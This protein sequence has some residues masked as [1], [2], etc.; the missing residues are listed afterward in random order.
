MQMLTGGWVSKTI[1]EVSRLNIPDLLA[2]H[3]P[4]SAEILTSQHQVKADTKFLHRALR[5]LASVGVFTENENGEFGATP[6]SEVL[7]QSS[8]VSVKALAKLFGGS[9]YRVWGGLGDALKEGK[10]QSKKILGM[11][12]WDYLNANP[13]ELEEFAEAMKA[14]SHNSL[15]GVLDHCDFSKVNRVIDVAGGL[16]HLAIALL[17]KYEKLKA[18]ILDMPNLESAAVKNGQ[19][20]TGVVARFDFVGGNINQYIR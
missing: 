20:D 5:A 7:T 12:H 9:A 16:G 11:E 18:T 15:Q 10:P 19:S 6:L 14:N 1:S 3:G 17:K 8:K 13:I 2:E 4:L